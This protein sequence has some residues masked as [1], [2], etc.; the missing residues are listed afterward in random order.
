MFVHSFLRLRWFVLR[1]FV[2]L[3]YYFA[4]DTTLLCLGLLHYIHL[5]AFG[6]LPPLLTI[7]K[8]H[9]HDHHDGTNTGTG[10]S[11]GTGTGDGDSDGFGTIF[12]LPWYVSVRSEMIR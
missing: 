9:H 3:P 5:L 11:T 12:M 6:T 2:L 7:A 1:S 10:T 4:S 8:Y